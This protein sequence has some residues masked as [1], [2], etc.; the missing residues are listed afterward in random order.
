MKAKSNTGINGW[1]GG[2]TLI[3]IMLALLVI[4]VGV[5][6]SIGLLSS[7][8]DTSTKSHDDLNMV[9]FADMVFNYC[10]SITNFNAI[11]STGTLQVPGYDQRMAYLPIGSKDRYAC[12]VPGFEGAS[13]EAY[14]VSY[15]LDVLS[16]GDVKALTLK[17]WPGYET[18]SPPR[19]FYTE[20]YNWNKN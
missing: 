18:G 16:E 2:F 20:I 6:A 1:C 13:R 19:I 3:E 10:Q 7:T 11:P 12:M 15:R 4:T 14:V 5:V 8:L 9:S 17:V